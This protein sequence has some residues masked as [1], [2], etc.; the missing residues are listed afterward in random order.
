MKKI[1]LPLLLL[2]SGI[3]LLSQHIE[4]DYETQKKSIVK[5]EFFSPLVG[6][7]TFGYEKYIKDWLSWEAKI[8]FIGL[9]T[10]TG[11]TDQSGLFLRGGPKFKLNPD[12]ITRDLRGSHLL[13]GKYIR[14]EIVISVYHEDVIE[15][16]FGFRTSTG[17]QTRESVAAFALIINYGRQYVL[18][19]IISMDWHFGIGY[20]FDNTNRGYHHSH[21]IVGDDSPAVFSGGFTVGVLL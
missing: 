21:R 11:S 18:S 16:Y 20:G 5:M 3:S 4:A 2:L 19:D 9:G 6:H 17:V 13:S 12:F 8:G 14:P 1:A 15:T 7:T 10:D